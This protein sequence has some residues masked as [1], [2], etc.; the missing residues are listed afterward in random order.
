VQVIASNH[1]KVAF[2]PTS[3]INKGDAKKWPRDCH[4]TYNDDF[5]KLQLHQLITAHKPNVL[6]ETDVQAKQ[7]GHF[8]LRFP[9][10]HYDLYGRT[11]RPEWQERQE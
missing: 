2:A 10:K 9:E 6:N 11:S 5:I 1:I 8:V 4:T 3:A 7:N